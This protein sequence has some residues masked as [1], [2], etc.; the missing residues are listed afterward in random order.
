MMLY[1]HQLFE[2]QTVL[3]LSD[4]LNNAGHSVT[5]LVYKKNVAIVTLVFFL[6]QWN[7]VEQLNSLLSTSKRRLTSDF[8]RLL[9]TEEASFLIL[10]TFH[11]VRQLSQNSS[12]TVQGRILPMSLSQ[13]H[14]S[15][16]DSPSWCC[17]QLCFFVC[18]FFWRWWRI[19][20]FTII[21]WAAL[22]SASWVSRQQTP[23]I[24]RNRSACVKYRL[25]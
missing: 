14:L 25:W 21:W 13:A 5:K 23:V 7:E 12:G 1:S 11:Q 6:I 9:W 24:N 2:V 22:V 4:T 19:A 15:P 20:V 8:W 3:L 17:V 16:Q 10:K 18:L